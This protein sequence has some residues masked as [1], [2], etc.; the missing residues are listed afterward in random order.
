MQCPRNAGFKAAVAA[1]AVGLGACGG[2]LGPSPSASLQGA[3][4]ERVHGLL[5]AADASGISKIKHVVIIIQENRSFN[6]LFMS[7]PGATTLTYGYDTSND[8]I[9]W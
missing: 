6:N 7:Y 1:A 3:N 2:N 4:P 5:H 8:K 9:L